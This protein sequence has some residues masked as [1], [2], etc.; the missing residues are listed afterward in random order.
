MSVLHGL[1]TLG[2]LVIRIGYLPARC[3]NRRNK[4]LT[5]NGNAV[6]VMSRKPTNLPFARKS[7][8]SLEEADRLGIYSINLNL[9]GYI[10]LSNKGIQNV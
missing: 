5:V 8:S 7:K 4:R 3:S 1:A 2:W 9:V 6:S 10:M